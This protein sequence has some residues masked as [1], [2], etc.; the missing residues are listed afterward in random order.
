[1]GVVLA[2]EL[3]LRRGPVPRAGKAEEVAQERPRAGVS[4]RVFS[5]IGSVLLL[6]PALRRAPGAS[7][8]LFPSLRLR[9]SAEDPEGASLV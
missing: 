4:V 3:Y 9:C 8:N 2:R 6:P 5:T 1:M 7:I